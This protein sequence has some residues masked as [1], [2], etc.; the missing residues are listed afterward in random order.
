MEPIHTYSANHKLYLIPVRDFLEMPVKNWRYNRQPDKGRCKEIAAHI[1]KSPIETVFYLAK[2]GTHYEVLD[3]IH[4]YTALKML[5]EEP[6]DYITADMHMIMTSMVLLNIRFSASEGALVD[7]F[8]SLNKS[9]PVPEL[10][11]KDPDQ[12][13]REV[14]EGVIKKWQIMYSDHFS[15][16]RKP[17]RPNINRD[18]FI[19]VLDAVYDKY[20]TEDFNIEIDDMEQILTLL[21]QGAEEAFA[22][23]EEPRK[24]IEKCRRT[25]L[26]MFMYNVDTMIDRA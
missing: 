12:V 10:Y 2:N 8:Q 22:G 21:N 3:G 19:E 6:A 1:K 25:G 4:R 17:V 7:A 20:K 5:L 16:S 9:I 23:T 18:T 13:K 15:P 24:A 11:M 14:I 26:W